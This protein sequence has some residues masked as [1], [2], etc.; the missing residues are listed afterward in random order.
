MILPASAV[1]R[2]GFSS[3][4]Q[5]PWWL[6]LAQTKYDP[7]TE[8]AYVELRDQEDDGD[9]AVVA[10]FSLRITAGFTQRQIEREIVRKALHLFKNAGGTLSGG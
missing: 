5:P 1:H 6:R 8:R 2:R 10:I 9:V 7:N 3:L 4:R